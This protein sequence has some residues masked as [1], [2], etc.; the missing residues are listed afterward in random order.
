MK[1]EKLACPGCG[2]P[3]SG[4]F[5]PNQTIHC[6]HCSVPLLITELQTDHPIFCP[7]CHTLNADEVYFCV[8]CG[9]RLKA[10]CVMCQSKNRLDTPYCARCG[11]HLERARQKRQSLRQQSQSLREQRLMVLKEKEVRQRQERLERLVEALDEPENHDLAV[12]QLSQLGSEAVE[13]LIETLLNNE[14]VDARYGSAR[15]LGQIMAEQTLR[16]DSPQQST[17]VQAL[18]QAMTDPEVAV[19]YWAVEALGKCR[20]ETAIPTLTPALTDPHKGIRQVTRLAL[21]S[22]GGAQAE[23]ALTRSKPNKLLGWLAK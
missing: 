16:G 15:A 4:D 20:S 6:T 11:V 21:Q 7:K 9:E 17:T 3:L 8:Q 1:L 10:E 2:A 18:M 5:S 14:D 22:I 19:R 13:V 12:L 23:A